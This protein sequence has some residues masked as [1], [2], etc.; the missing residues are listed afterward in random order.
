VTDIPIPASGDFDAWAR[1]SENV[2]AVDWDGTCKDTQIPKWTRAFNLAVTD[3]WPELAPHQAAV[4]AVCYEMN[5][6]D[7]VTAGE[8]RMVA[9]RLRM[10]RWRAMGLP[11]PDL[12]RF[13]AAA[14][15]IDQ[16]GLEHNPATYRALRAE[17]GFD[18]SPLRWSERSDRYIEAVSREADVFPHCRETLEAIGAEADLVVVSASKTENV[19]ADL[20]AH[21]MAALF[22]A[23]C[24][25]DFLSKAGTIAGLVERYR[26]VLFVGDMQHDARAAHASGAPLYLVRTGEEAASWASALD[27]FRRFCR[28]DR[29]IPELLWPQGSPAT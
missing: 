9:L 1:Q 12:E 4:D 20:R 8:P 6:T 10:D 2:I 15:A 26:R 7:P 16:R 23:L 22:K 3:V 19:L 17:F 29:D 27:V 5:L 13:R 21:D 11:A 14:R 18:D 24:A 25:Q 28:G